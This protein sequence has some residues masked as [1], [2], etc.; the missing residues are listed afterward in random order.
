MRLTARRTAQ[1]AD[2]QIARVSSEALLLQT[3]RVNSNGKCSIAWEKERNGVNGVTGAGRAVPQ[4]TPLA[5]TT[6]IAKWARKR[7]ACGCDLAR[8]SGKKDRVARYIR[9]VQVQ[10]VKGRNAHRLVE[11]G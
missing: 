5:K 1:P 8:D 7:G 9:S 3:Q 2:P 6:K 10:G 4:K 11:G